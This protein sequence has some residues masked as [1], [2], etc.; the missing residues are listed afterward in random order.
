MEFNQ[1]ALKESQIRK[2]AKRRYYELIMNNLQIYCFIPLFCRQKLTRRRY[3]FG[4]FR[5]RPH[6]TKGK[7]EIWIESCGNIGS[8]KVH[9]SPPRVNLGSLWNIWELLKLT[10]SDWIVDRYL[11]SSRWI[12][13]FWAFFVVNVFLGENSKWGWKWDVVKAFYVV[14]VS[15]RT[16][17]RICVGRVRKQE[18]CES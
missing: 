17:L 14:P 12:I 11:V 1:S 3:I 7:A 18:T 2:T 6:R 13:D 9:E 16:E 5:I 10:S 15:N 4:S 8:C